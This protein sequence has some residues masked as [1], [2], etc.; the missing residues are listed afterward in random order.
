MYLLN[1]NRLSHTEIKLVVATGAGDRRRMDWMQAITFTVDRQ[2][3]LLDSTG[4]C[5]QY[6][7][8][9]L[10]GKEYEKICVQLN[11]FALHPKLT[12]NTSEKYILAR[13]TQLQAG[14]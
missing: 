9:N 3:V 5:V 1:R 8:I 14:S 12:H 6:P 4:N 7:V 11:H 10:D 2:Q 13:F